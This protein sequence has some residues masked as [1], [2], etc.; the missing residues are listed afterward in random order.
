MET[1]VTIFQPSYYELKFIIRKSVC[2]EEGILPKKSIFTDV[3][4]AVAVSMILWF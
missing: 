4:V 3:I 1:A 2:V